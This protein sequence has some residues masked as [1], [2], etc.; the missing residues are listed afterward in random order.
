VQKKIAAAAI[1]GILLSP[2]SKMG[3]PVG[4]TERGGSISMR[5]QRVIINVASTLLLAVYLFPAEQFREW[6]DGKRPVPQ[7]VIP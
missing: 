5:S 1:G 4:M 3:I 7:F 6:M 2:G